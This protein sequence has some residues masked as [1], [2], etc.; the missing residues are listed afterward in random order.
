M[1]YNTGQN[2]GGYGD[3][4]GQQPGNTGLKRND[5]EGLSGVMNQISGP[6]DQVAGPN[7]KPYADNA[8][9]SDNRS[10]D[11]RVKAGQM[12]GRQ[13]AQVDTGYQAANQG[14]VDVAR[15]RMGE[16]YGNLQDIYAGRGPSMAQTQFQQMNDAAIRGQMAMANSARGATAQAGALRE[17]QLNAGQLGAQ[18][19]AT[20]GSLRAQEQL[21]A[22][23][24]MG[25]ATNNMGQLA[26]GQYGLE[27]QEALQ[28]A[29][30]Q[31]QQNALNDNATLGLYGLSRGEHN[32]AMGAYDAYMG[33]S[34]GAQG[35]QHEANKDASATGTN[36][37]GGLMSAAGGLIGGGSDARVKSDIEY[38]GGLKDGRKMTGL[39][40]VAIHD[41]QSDTRR[42]QLPSVT[43][44][45]RTKIGLHNASEASEADQFLNTLKPYSY[46]YKDTSYEP[47]AS[48]TG[49][50]YLGVMAQNLEKGPTGKTIVRE[51]ARGMK[52][53]EGGALMSALAAGTGRLHERLSELE[54]RLGKRGSGRN[55]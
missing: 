33:R 14:N 32:D 18:A 52:K 45:E 13:G 3:S 20:G 31:Q 49:G 47:T 37:F 23:Q 15:A 40:D 41:A 12:Q 1:A 50:R 36:I 2:S 53:L 5:S 10:Y 34:L 27:Q 19:A 9:V 8:N 51:D 46:Q 44:D 24:Q 29:G 48:P 7:R 39:A 25:A 30:L 43:S 6:G 16:Y 54:A 11:D 28:Q 42:R 4:Y 21:G 55:G 38:A 26:L 35:L 17:A 22:L